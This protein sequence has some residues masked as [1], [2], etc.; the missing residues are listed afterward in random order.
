M[1]LSCRCCG[2]FPARATSRK[3][4]RR[5]LARR[6]ALVRPRELGDDGATGG[7]PRDVLQL[8]GFERQ[9]G[10]FVGLDLETLIV[11]NAGNGREAVVAIN[12]IN[13]FNS[14]RGRKMSSQYLAHLM[15]SLGDALQKTL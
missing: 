2:L 11:R 7:A 6:I 9:C 10:P 15:A 13:I 8:L 4:R 14:N 3:T 5:L 12:P 1:T